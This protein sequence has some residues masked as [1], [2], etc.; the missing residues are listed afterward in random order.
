MP[1]TT[2]DVM[3]SGAAST[4]AP[5]P[6]RATD[7]LSVYRLGASSLSNWKVTNARSPALNVPVGPWRQSVRSTRIV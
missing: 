5:D 7:G 6:S 1:C 4:S 3:S 2:T